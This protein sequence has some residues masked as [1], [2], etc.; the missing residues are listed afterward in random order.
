MKRPPK[1][2]ES[3]WLVM[4]VLWKSAPRTAN[5]VVGELTHQTKWHPKTVKTLLGRLARKKAIG[6][7]KEGRA[8]SYYPLVREA[9]CAKAESASFL[10]RVYRGA[11]APMLANLLEDEALSDAEITELRRILDERGE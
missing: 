5:E 6:F 8:Y 7:K 2:A 1:I 3:E 4:R 11:L 10:K 9:E